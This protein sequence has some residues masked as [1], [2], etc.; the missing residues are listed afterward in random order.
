MI[1]YRDMTFC[2]HDGCAKFDKCFRAITNEVEAGSKEVGL[3]L[4]V[5]AEQPNC[6]ES[7]KAGE[8]RDE[9]NKGST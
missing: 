9:D 6:F 8:D 4:C 2:P 7:E 3:P 1:C 5:W